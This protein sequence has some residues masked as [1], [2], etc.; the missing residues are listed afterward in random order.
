MSKA[1]VP[2]GGGGGGCPLL[3]VG[4]WWGSR[5]A[6]LIV[7]GASRTARHGMTGLSLDERRHEKTRRQD[8]SGLYS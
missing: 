7:C 1:F 6:G 3:G 2:S 8:A 4:W 5:I